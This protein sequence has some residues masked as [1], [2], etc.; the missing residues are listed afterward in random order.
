MIK[1]TILVDKEAYLYLNEISRKERG[2]SPLTETQKDRIWSRAFKYNGK[3]VLDDDSIGGGDGTYCGKWWSWSLETIKDM[4]TK[5]GFKFE[6]GPDIEC[7][8]I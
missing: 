3:R 5:A 1:K 4:L 7:S 2:C 8:Y 6:D